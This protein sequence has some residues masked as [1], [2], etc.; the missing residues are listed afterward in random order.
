MSFIERVVAA[1]KPLESKDERREARAKARAAA[2][3][4]DWLA[5]MLQ[6]H[7]KIEALFGAVRAA[8]DATSRLHA[9]EELALVLTGD[10]NAEEAVIYPSPTWASW[11]TWIRKTLSRPLN[12]LRDFAAAVDFLKRAGNY[13]SSGSSAKYRS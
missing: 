12:S 9:L 4:N 6:H 13:D 10:A 8:Q 11:N 2:G 7:E 3:Q 5:P 1:V